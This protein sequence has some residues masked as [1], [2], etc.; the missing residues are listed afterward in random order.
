MDAKNILQQGDEA[1]YM[2]VIDHEGFDADTDHF[3]VELTWGM[4]GQSLT[5]DKADMTEG[6]F[7]TFFFD[8]N[9]AAMLGKVV[10]ACS[11]DI[12][13]ASLPDGYRTEVNRQILCFVTTSP[14]PKLVC[15]PVEP[16]QQDVIYTRVQTSD[17]TV[18]YSQLLTVNGEPILTAD[19]EAIYVKGD[20]GRYFLTYTGPEVQDL[21]DSINDNNS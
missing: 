21:L 2:I 15:C 8:F 10:A 5:L 7:G 3:A 17:V 18:N 4:S 11:Y 19:N 13:D 9:T 14:Q 12:P 1:K 16:A 6:D 20:T